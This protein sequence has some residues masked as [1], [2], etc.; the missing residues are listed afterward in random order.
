MPP[1][2]STPQKPLLYLI[3]SGATT[4]RTTPAT[5]DFSQLLHLVEASVIAGIDLIQIREKNLSASALYQLSAS[6]AAITR[7]SASRLLIND[8]ADIA[9]AAGADGVHLTTHSLPTAVVRRAFG[10]EFLIGVSTHSAQEAGLAH[11][12]G[13]DFV[14][15]G[16]VFKTESK[17]KYGAPQGLADLKKVSLELSPFPVL[18]LGGV[19]IDKAADCLDAGAQGVAGITMFANPDNLVD[20]VNALRKN[21]EKA[22]L[23]GKST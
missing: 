19:T 11:R 1:K 3:T 6:A 8:R 21:F 10:E 18:A 9:A 22:R 20:V 14:V 4:D 2:L 17:G 12:S 13:A 15:Y 23:R 16:P 7:G 5:K